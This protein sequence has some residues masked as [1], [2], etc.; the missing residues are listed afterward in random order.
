MVRRLCTS[1]C[2][3]AGS[4]CD[5]VRAIQAGQ[6]AR[7]GKIGEVAAAAQVQASRCGLEFKAMAPMTL[8]PAAQEAFLMKTLGQIAPDSALPK[9]PVQAGRR[10]LELKAMAP[11]TRMPAAQEAF[12]MKTLGRIAP[13]STLPKAPDSAIQKVHEHIMWDLPT[14]CQLPDGPAMPLVPTTSRT[15]ESKAKPAGPVETGKA[16][17]RATAQRAK[18]LLKQSQSP[19]EPITTLMLSN[20]PCSIDHQQVAKAIDSLGFSR[21]YDLLHVLTGGRSAAASR[22]NLGYGFINFL[23]PQDAE[24][25]AQAF[26]GYQ[27]EGTKSSKRS[28]VRPACVQGFA[29]TMELFR[30]SFAKRGFRGSVVC[31]L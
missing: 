9:A 21:R 17:R 19:D 6:A 25:F 10:G 24:A 13:D 2:R 27:F 8:S 26:N 30:H 7:Y 12:L 14:K 3:D 22:S 28:L 29:K 1:M 31:S 20:L 5:Q 23:T 18:E 11:M 15:P 4:T 16:S